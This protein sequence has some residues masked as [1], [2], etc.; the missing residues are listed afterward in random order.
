MQN[1]FVDQ[2]YKHFASKAGMQ[3]Q[4]HARIQQFTNAG[5]QPVSVLLKEFHARHG[6]KG[7]ATQGVVPEMVRATYMRVLKFFL[8]PITH[9]VSPHSFMPS[10]RKHDLLASCVPACMHAL[11]C[12]TN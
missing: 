8:F 3:A 2:L 7:F 10:P 12:E 9:K 11:N 5:N 4:R 1:L 6:L